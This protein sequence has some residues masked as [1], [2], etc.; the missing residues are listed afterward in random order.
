[1]EKITKKRADK[2]IRLSGETRGVTLKTDSEYVLSQKGKKALIKV[3]AELARIGYPLKY[4]QIEAMNF[5][6]IGLRM[7]SL[8]T[9]QKVLGFTNQD[10][11]KMGAAAP[12]ISL[13]IKLF[14]KF[15]FSLEKTVKQAPKMWEKHYSVGDFYAT[16][17]EKKKYAVIK[18][19]RLDLDPVFCHYLKGYLSTIIQMIVDARVTVK[20]TK[21]SFRDKNEKYHEFE[22]KW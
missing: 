12:K 21:C 19:K 18:L 1:M 6:P 10:I 9:I 13:V 16:A 5:Y 15:F 17:Y 11:K 20:E 7:I 14:A 8:L 2:L 3:E 22:L 4:D